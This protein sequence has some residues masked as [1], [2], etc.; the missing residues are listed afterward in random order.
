MDKPSFKPRMSTKSMLAYTLSYVLFC[1]YRYSLKITN[2]LTEEIKKLQKVPKQCRQVHWCYSMCQMLQKAKE[3]FCYPWGGR[4]HWQ[5]IWGEDGATVSKNTRV[6]RWGE[7]CARTT[8]G[9]ENGIVFWE[10]TTI[11]IWQLLPEKF[12]WTF[13][14]R[15]GI[16]KYLLIIVMNI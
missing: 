9:R 8:S 12:K 4:E 7:A 10:T 5:S 11:I 14:Y 6:P 1:R 3:R 15:D 16:V 2:T 13:R